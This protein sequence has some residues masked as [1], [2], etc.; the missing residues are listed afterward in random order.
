MS[1][2]GAAVDVEP[3]LQVHVNDEPLTYNLSSASGQ[4]E[5]HVSEVRYAE[6]PMTYQ[7]L[8]NDELQV[9]ESK[10]NEAQPP[11][12][13]IPAGGEVQEPV[14][15]VEQVEQPLVYQFDENRTVP[16]VEEP[17][18]YVNQAREE[19]LTYTFDTQSKENSQAPPT[20][21]QATPSVT[22]AKPPINPQHS[23]S[24]KKEEEPVAIVKKDP[25]WYKQMFQQLQNN[26]EEDSQGGQSLQ[27]NCCS[28]N[29]Q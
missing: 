8:D 5:E 14:Y 18:S 21:T 11:E 20:G 28:V 26:V 17:V 6:Q 3:A 7:D 25:G 23:A 12:A 9:E 13:N 15:Q 2:S 19:S 24:I 10:I 16:V 22:A 27:C 29:V 1:T 4:V